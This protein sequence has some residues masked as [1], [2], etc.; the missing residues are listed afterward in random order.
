MSIV[1]QIG[2]QV[3]LK[4]K[5][6]WAHFNREKTNGDKKGHWSIGKN[7]GIVNGKNWPG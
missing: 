3:K 7:S 2:K 4:A 5:L 6:N 1:S